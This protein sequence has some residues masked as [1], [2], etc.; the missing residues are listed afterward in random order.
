MLCFSWYWLLAIP[1][2]VLAGFIIVP[3]WLMVRLP[4]GP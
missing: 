3:I 1:A 2:L 4:W